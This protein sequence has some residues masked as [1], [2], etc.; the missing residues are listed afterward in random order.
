MAGIDNRN[1]GKRQQKLREK[2]IEM[3]GRT[4]TY[5][6]NNYNILKKTGKQMDR[7]IF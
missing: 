2:T 7:I 4:I 3:A 1:G 5:L 6:A